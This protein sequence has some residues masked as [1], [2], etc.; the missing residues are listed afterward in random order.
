LA[1]YSTSGF[2]LYIKTGLY[3]ILYPITY[4]NIKTEFKN[5]LI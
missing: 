5:T 1:L 3:F 2:H 4:K